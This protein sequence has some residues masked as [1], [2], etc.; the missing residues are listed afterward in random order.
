MGTYKVTVPVTVIVEIDEENIEAD[1]RSA[2]QGDSPIVAIRRAIACLLYSSPDERRRLGI[3]RF[4][5]NGRWED[6]PVELIGPDA[7]YTATPA[8]KYLARGD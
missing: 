8:Q 7:H 5:I 3:R 1:Q 4:F 2:L 6:I